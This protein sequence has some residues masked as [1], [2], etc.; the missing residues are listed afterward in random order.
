AA[1]ERQ[2]ARGDDRDDGVAHH[3]FNIAR[4][5]AALPIAEFLDLA[6]RL[7][8]HWDRFV[9]ESS[10][11]HDCRDRAGDEL[12]LAAEAAYR[13]APDPRPVLR[14]L[15]AGAATLATRLALHLAA[16]YP[17]DSREAR[18]LT[19]DKR[20]RRRPSNDLKD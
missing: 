11:C 15:R 20:R 19:A 13:R 16:R 6:D 5:L 9:A 8:A 12:A 3:A 4:H 18:A 1:A 14:R 7:G 17:L 2:F 10:Y